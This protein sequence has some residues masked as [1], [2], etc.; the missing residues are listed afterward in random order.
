MADTA[1]QTHE[2]V[3][4]GAKGLAQGNTFGAMLSVSS[5]AQSS[6]PLTGFHR[7]VLS[8]PSVFQY[9]TVVFAMAV[10]ILACRPPM[11]NR[12]IL[13]KIGAGKSLTLIPSAR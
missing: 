11:V 4:G 1:V 12:S 9:V 10:V 13:R 2:D 7:S 3:A 5:S 8:G 6:M